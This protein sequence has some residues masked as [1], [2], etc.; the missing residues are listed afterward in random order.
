[1]WAYYSTW[2]CTRYGLGDRLFSAACNLTSDALAEFLTHWRESAKYYLRS[3][4]QHLIGCCHP[5]LA[6]TFPDSIPNLT[7][8]N[9]YTHPITSSPDTLVQLSLMFCRRYPHIKLG[10]LADFRS[11]RFS[12]QNP[13]QLLHKF[14]LS[15]WPGLL[16]RAI[17]NWLQ[18]DSIHMVVCFIH[19]ADVKV[20][21]THTSGR[22]SCSYYIRKPS[23]PSPY[24]R[25]S[26]LW[27][28]V[29]A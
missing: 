12:W 27:G 23:S 18:Q 8:L 5:S 26:I 25:Y 28:S 6:D 20:A 22:H 4:P 10:Q 21:N 11:V 3:D 9:L 14:E 24:Q 16:L 29:L 1:M 13:Y 19:A 15:V 2:A 7:A 17:I